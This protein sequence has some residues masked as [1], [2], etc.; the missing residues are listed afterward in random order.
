MQNVTEANRLNLHIHH[1]DAA[2]YEKISEAAN[3]IKAIKLLSNKHLE[4]LLQFMHVI[5]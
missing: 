5:L 2:V 4:P 3:Y 1:I